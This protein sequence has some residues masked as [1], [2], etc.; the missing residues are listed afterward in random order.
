MSAFNWMHYLGQWD[1]PKCL[2]W[3]H[4]GKRRARSYRPEVGRVRGDDVAPPEQDVALADGAV[5]GVE[6]RKV[7]EDD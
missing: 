6:Q 2:S 5:L 3:G 7:D 1:L 4:R